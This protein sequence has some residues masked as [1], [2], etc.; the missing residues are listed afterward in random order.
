MIK[1][2]SFDVNDTKL[3]VDEPKPELSAFS[4]F[5]FAAAV[6][7]SRFVFINSQ[8]FLIKVVLRRK[9]SGASVIAKDLSRVM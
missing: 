3:C 5:A 4:A 2:G 6:K 8:L 7:F 1:I 9:V